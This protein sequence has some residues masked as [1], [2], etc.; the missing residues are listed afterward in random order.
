MADFIDM[1]LHYVPAVDD[2]V[3]SLE[4]GIALCQGLA[5]LGYGQLVTTPHIR[6]AMFENTASGLRQAFDAFVGATKDTPGMPSLEL[7]AEHFFDD[8]FLDL[9]ERGEIVPYPG[10]HAALVE[11]PETQTPM[12]LEQMVFRM[13]IRRVAP[14]L[15]HP[16][17]HL[18]WARDAA[19]LER[20]VDMGMLAQ[21]DLM[22]LVGRYGRKPRKAAERMLDEGLYFVAGTDAHRPRDVEDVAEAIRLLRRHLG[23]SE[24]EEL[25]SEN[26]R[27]VLDGRL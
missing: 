12:G 7:A 6:T 11:L 2:G 5:K 27:R 8:V 13:N 9:F 4:E 23:D 26:P 1:H 19:P 15:A 14:V 10:G 20:L 25:L 22:S 17:R 24:A 21:L 18:P 3:R 16:E